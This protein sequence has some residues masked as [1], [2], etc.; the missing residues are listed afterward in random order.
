[1]RRAIAWYQIA[2]GLLGLGVMVAGALSGS[3]GSAAAYTMF[4]VPFLAVVLA[5]VLLLRRHRAG[6]VLTILVQA[7]QV[8]FFDLSGYAYKFSSGFF[9]GERLRGGRLG[10]VATLDVSFQVA[11]AQDYWVPLIGVNAVPVVI[12]GALWY[13]GRASSRRLATPGEASHTAV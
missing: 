8:I 7:S 1:M 6:V 4:A 3:G 12:L 13:G 10:F 11:W 2:G 9:L 5:G